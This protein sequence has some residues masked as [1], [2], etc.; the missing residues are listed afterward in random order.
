MPLKPLKVKPAWIAAVFMLLLSG[1]GGTPA[2]PM[3]EAKDGS[4]LLKGITGLEKVSQIT[5]AEAP[6]RTD[7]Y[8]VYGTDLGSMINEGDKTY[9]VFGDT[10]GERDPGQIGGGGSYWRSNTIGYTSD[11]RPEDGITLNGM[12]TDEFGT[13]KE[14]LPSR[15]IDFDE[16]TTIPTHGLAAGGALYLYYMSVNHWGEPGSWDA[17]FAGVAKSTDQGQNWSLLENLQWP[18]DSNF[19]QVSPY[20][21]KTAGDA[22]DIYF[23]CIP[24][25]RSGGVKLMKVGEESIEQLAAY[26]YYAGQDEKGAPIWSPDMNKAQTVVEDTAGEL[27]VVW[28]SYLQ[29][30]LMT[31]LREGQGAVIREGLTPWGPWGNP[32]DLVK[33]SEEPGLYAPFMNERYTGDNGKTIYFTLS[34]WDPYNVFWFKASLQK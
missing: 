7:R 6:G 4:F 23:W 28:N 17:N 16:M 3:L 21:V 2:N 1:C 11:S 12:I 26:R 18:G 24:S 30:W 27:S 20:K 5:G 29:R 14:L 10:F 13:A 19:I 15:K 31:Y 33:A 25:G 8:A 34:L 32:I 9:F 22:A